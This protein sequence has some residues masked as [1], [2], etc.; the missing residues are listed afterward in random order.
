MNATVFSLHLD[1]YRYFGS[2]IRRAVAGH[3][4]HVGSFEV[5]ISMD[6]IAF[7]H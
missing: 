5:C 2:C 6:S 7:M 4:L 1:V 3:G